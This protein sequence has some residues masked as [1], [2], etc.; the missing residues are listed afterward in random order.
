M[1][2]LTRLGESQQLSRCMGGRD[3]GF[4]DDVCRNRFVRMRRAAGAT[5]ETRRI[6]YKPPP[7]A[8]GVAAWTPSDDAKLVEALREC[9]RLGGWMRVA[10]HFGWTRTAQACRNRAI[11][12]G[13]PRLA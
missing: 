12:L 8:R 13:I 3:A 11:R 7:S 10:A 4:S 9:S 2:T 1:V 5:Y 6:R